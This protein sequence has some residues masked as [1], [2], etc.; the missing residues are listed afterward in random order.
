[1]NEQTQASKRVQ[2]RGLMAGVAA[3]VAGVLAKAGSAGR[4]EAGH[5][6]T[7]VFHL[8]EDNTFGTGT[9]T[10]LSGSGGGMLGALRVTNS[11]GRGITVVP[12]GGSTGV[13]AESSFLP[14]FWGSATEGP[15]VLG[16]STQFYGVEGNSSNGSGVQGGSAAAAGTINAGVVGNASLVSGVWGRSTS[17]NGVLGQSSAGI[18]VQ[19]QSIGS[20]GVYGHSINNYAVYGASQNSAGVFGTSISGNSLGVYGQSQS[21]YGVYGVSFNSI[22][23]GAVSQN[24]TAINASSASNNN[25]ALQVVQSGS[26]P[27][28]AFY[29]SVVV[30]GAFTVVGAKNAA[31]PHPDGSHRRLYCMESP[32]SYFEDFGEARLVNGRAQV[33]LD[34]DFAAVVHGDN[35]RVFCMPKGDTNGLFVSSQS[36]SGFEVRETKGGTGTLAFDYRVVAKRKDIPGPRLEKVDLPA[37]DQVPTVPPP[38]APPRLAPVAPVE[39]PARPLE[40]P[41]RGPQR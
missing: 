28:A 35:Y 6:G 3:L 37:R 25:P 41:G 11:V 30:N 31:V 4:A 5:T 16:D 29:G 18:G 34:R 38:P 40:T 20:F 24:S 19:G 39:P 15:G 17:S 10:T 8:G 13:R 14:A 9:T 33:R 27:A 21:S 1:M 23:V 26:A 32:E 2:R 36:P 7:N 22:G 12:A